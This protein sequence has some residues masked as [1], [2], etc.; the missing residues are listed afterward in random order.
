MGF[1][2]EACG[3]GRGSF[4][5]SGWHMAF[6]SASPQGK[7]PDIRVVAL[8]PRPLP[9]SPSQS[10]EELGR[11]EKLGA[12]VALNCASSS[13]SPGSGTSPEP[14]GPVMVSPPCSSS[15]SEVKL[16]GMKHRVAP[17]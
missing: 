7:Q 6:L 12:G 5:G 9:H 3:E 8:L 11:V 17:C 16:L 10:R 4:L 2:Q 14:Q 15:F 1:F 13:P